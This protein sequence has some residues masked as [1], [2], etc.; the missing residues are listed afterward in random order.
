MTFNG[1]ARNTVDHREDQ[2]MKRIIHSACIVLLVIFSG[3]NDH[4]PAGGSGEAAAPSPPP[5][6]TPPPSQTLGC[7]TLSFAKTSDVDALPG[8][9]WYG[10]LIDCENNARYDYL[11]ALVSE[12]GRFRVIGENGHLLSGSL[13]TDGDTFYGNGVDFAASGIEYF[14]GPT[15]ALFVQGSVLER[16]VLEGR[17]GTEWGFYGYFSFIYGQETYEKPISLDLLAGVWP[18]YYGESIEGVWTIEADGRFN[19]QDQSGCLQSGHLALIDD[20]FS[21]L[22]VELTVTGC[23][24]AGSYTGLAYREELVDW[25]DET[26]TLSVDDGQQALRILLLL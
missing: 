16:N 18:S 22:E 19:G 25:W 2:A 6:Q 17:W 8:G 24:L 13:Q 3:C 10:S 4:T 11:T 9:V 7:N 5:V 14:S 26:I 21:M 23:E 20:R 1:T 12:D 15:T